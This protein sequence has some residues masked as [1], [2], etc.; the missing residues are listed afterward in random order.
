MDPA[1]LTENPPEVPAGWKAAWSDEH[2]EWFYVNLNTAQTT[3]DK[4]TD[5]AAPSY[6]GRK[7]VI[8]PSSYPTDPESTGADDG[9]D[10]LPDYAAARAARRQNDL[11]F[12]NEILSDYEFEDK[13]ALSD[14]STTEIKAWSRK[15][16]CRVLI[17]RYS[18][19]DKAKVAAVQRELNALYVLGGNDNTIPPLLDYFDPAGTV[20][21]ICET[22]QDES[23][24][25]YIEGRGPLT[26]DLLKAVVTQLM[27][28]LSNIFLNGFAHLKMCDETLSID[29]YGQLTIKDF[30][31]AIPY[32]KEKTD[33]LYAAVGHEV[34]GTEGIWR[35]PEVFA[36]EKEGVEYNGRKA[37]IWSC[38]IVLVWSPFSLHELE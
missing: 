37:V 30:Q 14:E 12:E 23:L 32:G 4:P 27:S 24:K 8:D 34:K 2:K 13:S 15:S 33:T 25:Q 9:D 36:A 19:S 11:N 28:A 16:S 18:K 38:G 26:G 20:F 10:K 21:V 3:W 31:Y 7:I 35:A 5:V 6:N 1:R 17:K 22:R 29:A